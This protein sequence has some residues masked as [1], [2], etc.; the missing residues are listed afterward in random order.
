MK[1]KKKRKRAARKTHLLKRFFG[2]SALTIFVGFMFIGFFIMFFTAGQWWNEKVDVMTKNAQN[3]AATCSDLMDSDISEKAKNEVINTSLESIY[4]ATLSE[5][6]ITDLNGEVTYCCNARVNEGKVCPTHEN[7][8]VSEDHMKRAID[9]GFTDYTTEDEFGIGKFV[10]AVPI[11]SGEKVVGVSYAIEDAITGF[12]PYVA[13][14]VQATSYAIMGTLLII[15]IVMFFITRSITKPLSQMKEVTE[16]YAKGEFQYRADEGYK[17]RDFSEFAKALNKMA[18]ELKV[19]EDAQ[20]S[21]VAN[22][23]HELKTPM[24]SIGGFI[25]GVLDG[26][27]PP[28]EEKKYLTVVSSEVKRLSR[29]VVSMLN[30]SKFEA[31]EIKI[32]PRDYDVSKQIFDTLLSFERRIDEKKIEIRGFEHMGEVIINADKDLLQ[33]VIYNL[34]DNAV[35]FTPEGGYIRVFAKRNEDSTIVSIRNSGAGVSEDE[36]A[37]IFERFYKVDKSRSYDVKGVGLGLYI[38][39]T[40]INMH[41]GGIVANSKQ[42]EYTEFS[43][44]IPN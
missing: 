22:V 30:L 21:F 5:Y 8:K 3:I 31:G 15:F 7:F 6:F 27:I 26:T 29:M 11:K 24:T 18:Y 41:D 42:G 44:E 25:D 35:K 40:I 9:G 12:L 23:S 19:N 1:D 2:Y 20:K 14:I 34:V 36:I 37:R 38:V 28:E 16:H 33:Q 10:V 32:S 4:E 13:G 17:I 43:F 39:K